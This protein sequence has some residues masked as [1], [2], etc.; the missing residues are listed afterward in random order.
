MFCVFFLISDAY[1]NDIQSTNFIITGTKYVRLLSGFNFF[2][3][4]IVITFITSET[5][6]YLCGFRIPR[7][8]I[9]P[10]ALAIDVN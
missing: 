2:F 3:T 9:D 5:R 7:V 10:T 6:L 8:M 1:K 4:I